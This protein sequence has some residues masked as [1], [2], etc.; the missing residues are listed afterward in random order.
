MKQNIVYWEKSRIN[1][2]EI[3]YY[4]KAENYESQMSNQDITIA[5]YDF[6][7]KPG[8]NKYILIIK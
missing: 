6:A 5:V 2:N 4:K 7:R 8:Y 3:F 1:N